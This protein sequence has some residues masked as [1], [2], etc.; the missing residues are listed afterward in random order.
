MHHQI[1]LNYPRFL[2]SLGQQCNDAS[3]GYLRQV[4][5]DVSE[6]SASAIGR[7]LDE[8]RIQAYNPHREHWHLSRGAD[9]RR[10]GARL[11]CKILQLRAGIG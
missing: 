11:A 8:S 4:R 2:V 5:L 9:E 7:S 3:N 6:G 1:R 10:L